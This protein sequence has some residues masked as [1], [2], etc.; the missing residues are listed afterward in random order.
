MR[1]GK[2]VC[3]GRTAKCTRRLR[4]EPMLQPFG[5]EWIDSVC[6]ASAATPGG[7]IAKFHRAAATAARDCFGVRLSREHQMPAHILATNRGSVACSVV[8]GRWHATT[9]VRGELRRSR[10]R[11]GTSAT[12]RHS[13]AALRERPAETHAAAVATRTEGTASGTGAPNM[14]L[15]LSGTRARRVPAGTE[16]AIGSGGPGRRSSWSS[17]GV[18]AVELRVDAATKMTTTRRVCAGLTGH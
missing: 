7:C 13:R 17:S 1:G 11:A 16:R 15:L 12:R 2:G 5:L 8:C 10:R 9:L 4:P 14:W 6:E 3:S 18:E